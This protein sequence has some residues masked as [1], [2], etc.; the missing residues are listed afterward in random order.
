MKKSG[1]TLA[2]AIS[3]LVLL[4]TVAAITIPSVWHN[5]RVSAD[6][7]RLKKAMALYD[8]VIRTFTTEN[9]ITT[10]DKLNRDGSA[11]S[12]EGIR[13]YFKVID[14]NGSCQFKTVEGVWWDMSNPAK[15]L[16]LKTDC[17]I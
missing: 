5:V 1:F 11:N 3:V 7:T 15:S 9:R 16:A 13:R 2:E 4:G 14:G 10:I 12:C 6:R 17:I 8:S